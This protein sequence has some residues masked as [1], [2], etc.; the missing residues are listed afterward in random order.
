MPFPDFAAQG[1][2]ANHIAQCAEAK[3]NHGL[4]AMTRALEKQPDREIK[5]IN[6]VLE[7]VSQRFHGQTQR[8]GQC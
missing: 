2:G 4:F 8:R 3:N 6:A 1:Q 7:F 5:N